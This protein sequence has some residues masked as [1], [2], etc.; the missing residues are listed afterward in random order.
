MLAAAAGFARPG[1]GLLCRC[2]PS[3]AV[4]IFAARR[5]KKVGVRR[6]D[7]E[8]AAG[9]CGKGSASMGR[10][11][12][13][14]GAL[15]HIGHMRLPCA[16]SRRLACRLGSARTFVGPRLCFSRGFVSAGA[17]CGGR[18]SASWPILIRGLSLCLRLLHLRLHAVA[19]VLT[20]LDDALEFPRRLRRHHASCRRGSR[21]K[22]ELGP[23]I[24]P[25]PPEGRAQP[26]KCRPGSEGGSHPTTTPMLVAPG[27][28]SRSGSRPMPFRIARAC[29]RLH[30]LASSRAQTS[31]AATSSSW[32]CAKSASVSR[33]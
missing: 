5:G 1:L 3:H 16:C 11:A 15:E 4:P 23:R 21:R 26:A 2:L 8:G 27:A 30:P 14:G 29:R 22:C 25:T 17:G 7:S 28:S 33:P 24:G 12:P 9:I 13:A 6:A 32:S 19:F 18:R 10:C 20:V 31:S